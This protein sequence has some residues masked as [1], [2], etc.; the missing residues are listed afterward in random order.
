MIIDAHQHFWNLEKVDYPWL[1]A[2]YGPLYRTYTPAELMPQLEGAGV[3]ATVLVQA[4][5][6]YQ[7]T[8]SMLAQAD[9]HDWIAGVVGWVPLT[10]PEETAAGLE[11][12]G[13][14]PKFVGIRHLMHEEADP[15]W[16][17]QP[18]IQESLGILA[19]SGAT[20]DVVSV[21]PR[22]LEHIPVLAERHRNLKLVID[23]LS[24]PPIKEK[25]WEPW[26]G[27]LARAAAYPN[28]YAK[29]S[30]LNTAADW[31]SWDANDLAPYIEHA[32]SVFGGDRLMFGSDWP[33]AVLAGSYQKVVDE[34]ETALG[35]AGLEQ[36]AR[37]AVW[38]ATA[39]EFYGLTPAS[40]EPRTK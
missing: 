22:H 40:V 24:K 18:E 32:V 7:D 35:L 38:S 9:E 31:K 33:V 2:E 11:R 10:R 16:V 6:S 12:F 30:G 27:L 23:H 37:E 20:F 29:V 13:K 3:R 15:D 17:L 8:E 21:L 25:G 14:H 4:A 39:I 36:D 34:T 19:E 1:T 28:V 5:D 26:A